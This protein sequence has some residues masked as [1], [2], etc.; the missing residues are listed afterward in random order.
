LVPNVIIAPVSSTARPDL[1]QLARPEQAKTA[2]HRLAF[3]RW[4]LSFVQPRGKQMRWTGRTKPR[5]D[6]QR[7]LDTV[8]GLR[9]SS[10][11]F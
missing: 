9:P 2:L 11:S 1:P 10:C 5:F 6:Q 3:S 7:S 8:G 4:L